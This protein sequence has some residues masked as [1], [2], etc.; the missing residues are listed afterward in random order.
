MI[1]GHSLRGDRGQW[2]FLSHP[3]GC[4]VSGDIIMICF[5]WVYYTN[6]KEVLRHIASYLQATTTAIPYSHPRAVCIREQKGT[7]SGIRNSWHC[8][9]K[10]TPWTCW[11]SVDSVVVRAPVEFLSSSNQPWFCR[12]IALNVRDR[13]WKV[14][15]SPAVAKHVICKSIQDIHLLLLHSGKVTCNGRI[16]SM[17][18]VGS[19]HTTTPQYYLN[20]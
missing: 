1:Y 10:L 4:M 6:R 8:I 9:E 7:A 14:R 12:R 13:S 16:I 11:A 19:V 3:S 15:F 17:Y 2:F 5:T 20:T 18:A